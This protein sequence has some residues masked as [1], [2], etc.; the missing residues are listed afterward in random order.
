MPRRESKP[1][2]R[3]KKRPTF[4]YGFRGGCRFCR[5]KKNRVGYKETDVLSRYITEQG[6]ILPS[7]ISRTCARHQ[8]QL[9]MAIKR[10]RAACLLPYAKQ[11]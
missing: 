4:N 1:K 8:R 6:K 3:F 2:R 11:D 10:A 5:D 7:R 9:A